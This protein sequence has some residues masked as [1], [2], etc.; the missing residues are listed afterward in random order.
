MSLL[1]YNHYSYNIYR[2][3]TC[4]FWLQRFFEL[5][6]V[7]NVFRY[8]QTLTCVGHLLKDVCFHGILM[9][10]GY[11]FCFRGLSFKTA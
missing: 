7:K 9:E 6:T 4:C 1:L 10:I 2:S 3:L 5:S 8:D 11:T